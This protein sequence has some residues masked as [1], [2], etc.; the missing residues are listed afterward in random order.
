MRLAIAWRPDQQHAA[1]RRYTVLLIDLTRGKKAPKILAQATFR[2]RR[3]NQVLESCAL[4]RSEELL[5]LGPIAILV[6]QNL[7]VN[8]GAICA[9]GAQ[10]FIRDIIGLRNDPPPCRL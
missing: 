4:D 1:L 8:F 10:K 5:I 3:Q 2:V 9:N 6:N 7:A